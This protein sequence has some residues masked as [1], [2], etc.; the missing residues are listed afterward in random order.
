MAG[1]DNLIPLNKRPKEEARKIQSK[2]GK[3]SAKA[4]R[5]RKTIRETME[6]LLSQPIT[7][8]KT[9]SQLKRMGMGMDEDGNEIEITNVAII[10][11]SILQGVLMGDSKMVAIAIKLMGEDA[12]DKL[13]LTGSLDLT[14]KVSKIQDYLSAEDD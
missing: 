8:R 12:G 2:G 5:E 3:A 7:D 4:S 9:L 1:K 13:E 14:E 6:M 11:L 10:P